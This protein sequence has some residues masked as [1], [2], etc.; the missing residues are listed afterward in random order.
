MLSPSWK[1][2]Y[3]PE[4]LWMVGRGRFSDSAL[5]TSTGLAPLPKRLS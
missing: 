2:L 3:I 1:C 5:L 4:R